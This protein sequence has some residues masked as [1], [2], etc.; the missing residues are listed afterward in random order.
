MGVTEPLYGI[1]PTTFGT[2]GI[3]WIMGE[4]D[5][6]LITALQLPDA[7]AGWRPAADKR[8]G[9]ESTIDGTPVTGLVRKIQDYFL[10]N[11]H[12]LTD[13]AV[14]LGEVRSFSRQ[15]YL[16]C[17]KIPAGKTLSYGELAAKIGRPGSARAVGQALARNPIP[18]IIP[19]HRVLS[20]KGRVGGFSAPG[21]VATKLKMLELE[22][23]RIGC[24]D[25]ESLQ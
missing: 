4:R 6:P 16:V 18:L 25:G 21:G 22:G 10:G 8:W 3:A 24:D 12:D 19:C 20:A 14:D 1:F 15:V 9:R 5:V 17:R 2:C 11:I 23:V 7:G 13:I